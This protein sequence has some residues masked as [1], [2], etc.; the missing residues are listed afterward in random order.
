MALSGSW[1]RLAIPRSDTTLHELAI[2]LGRSRWTAWR[3]VR[4]LHAS[5]LPAGRLVVRRWRYFGECYTRKVW[6]VRGDAAALLFIEQLIRSCRRAGLRRKY[7]EPFRRQRQEI[8]EALE[9]RRRDEKQFARAGC[10]ASGKRCKDGLPRPT[11]SV[12]G[13]SG[14]ASSRGMTQA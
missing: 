3:R 10:R 12:A 6:A 9:A 1:A 11:F 5:G 2:L 7:L 8:L 4:R 14:A 13:R